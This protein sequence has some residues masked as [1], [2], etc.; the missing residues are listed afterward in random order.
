[1][2][3]LRVIGDE[4]ARSLVTRAE[5]TE[6]VIAAYHAAAQGKADVSKPS[7]V[8][9]R[10][11]S[12]SGTDIKVKGAVLDTLNVAGFRMR[13]YGPLTTIGSHLYVMAAD[14]GQPLGLVSEFWLHR[15][16]TACTALVTCRALLPEGAKRLA[17]IGTG[18]ITE[19]FIRRLRPAPAAGRDRAGVALDRTG[20]RKP[21]TSG[22][23]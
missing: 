3:T 16:R 15:A 21:P 1:M 11:L 6:L 4:E 14:T 13:P 23:R 5:V 2:S 12:G 8:M 17:L 18:R 10:G 19:E 9:M 20:A 22:A 7:A